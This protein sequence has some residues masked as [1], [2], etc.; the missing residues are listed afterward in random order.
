LATLEK[1]RGDV[2]LVHLIKFYHSSV[3]KKVVVGVT[4]LIMFLFLIAHMAGNLK[5]FLGQEAFDHYAASLR[6]IAEAFVGH[7]TVLWVSRIVLLLAVGL[8][9]LTV[10]QLSLRNRAARPVGYVKTR[11]RAASFSARLMMVTGLTLLA[12]IVFHLLHLTTGSIRPGP[13]VEGRVYANVYGSFS[14][15]WVLALYVVGVA[16]VAFHLY[17]GVWSLLQTLGLNNPDRE[18]C[19]RGFSIVMSV[20]LFV[21][22]C[23]MPVAVFTGVLPPP[24]P[25]VV[26]A[27]PYT[28]VIP[29][30]DPAKSIDPLVKLS[31]ANIAGVEATTP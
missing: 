15:G 10:I 25:D 1:K 22:F 21:G 2:K 7:G 5:A 14:R 27:Q 23:A 20:L 8:H 24:R 30:G 19:T 29:G 12:F 26:R 16:V 17:H 9:I 6:S 28:G 31:S 3:G 18:R 11:Y 13:F 4:G